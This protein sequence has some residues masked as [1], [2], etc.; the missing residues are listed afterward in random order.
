MVLKAVITA[1]IH[2][3]D[4]LAYL[5]VLLLYSH[6]YHQIKTVTV[7]VETFL[8]TV[9]GGMTA[10]S[11]LIPTTVIGVGLGD[12]SANLTPAVPDLTIATA[13]FVLS[14]IIATVSLGYVAP[15]IETRGLVY[16]TTEEDKEYPSPDG[17]STVEIDEWVLKLV[18]H[19]GFMQFAAILFGGIRIMSA[20]T[21]L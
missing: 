13:W 12:S 4:I 1:I 2:Y 7:N 15:N 20:L 16:C 11:I 9:E 8:G 6:Y 14:L 5:V 19:L 18:Y 3:L 17:I 10:T 21:K